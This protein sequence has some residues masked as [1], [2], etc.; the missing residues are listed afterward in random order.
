MGKLDFIRTSKTF[1][2]G[3][4]GNLGNSNV[5]G[6]FSK[7]VRAYNKTKN[8]VI[9]DTR[10]DFNNMGAERQDD[11]PLNMTCREGYGFVLSDGQKNITLWELFRLKF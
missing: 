1:I 4:Q 8:T 3:A 11:N 2:D 5:D 9:T 10:I 7:Q 6:S